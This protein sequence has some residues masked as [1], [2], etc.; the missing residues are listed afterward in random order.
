METTTPNYGTIPANL[1]YGAQDLL[2]G[3][4]GGAPF[5]FEPG[6][7]V[8]GPGGYTEP[9]RGQVMIGGEWYKFTESFA[10]QLEAAGLAPTTNVEGKDYGGGYLQDIVG[11]NLDQYGLVYG[12]M[13]NIG[14]RIEDIG[15]IAHGDIWGAGVNLWQA[16][17]GAY[18]RRGRHPS[19]GAWY[20][21]PPYQPL[22]YST[23]SLARGA[24]SDIAYQTMQLSE[25]AAYSA[26]QAADP[27]RTDP[28]GAAATG[29]GA[30]LLAIGTAFGPS[31][32]PG[33]AIDQF[34][35]PTAIGGL[36]G[37]YT[38]G[39]ETTPDWVIN[40]SEFRSMNFVNALATAS[41]GGLAPSFIMGAAEWAYRGGMLGATGDRYQFANAQALYTAAANWTG[42]PDEALRYRA[43]AAAYGAMG[44][45]APEEV[46]WYGLQAS[47]YFW[48]G[49]AGAGAGGYLREFGWIGAGAVQG[50]AIGAATEPYMRQLYAMDPQLTEQYISANNYQSYLGFNYGY[51]PPGPSL[52]QN[53]G[54]WGLGYGGLQAGVS[55]MGWRGLGESLASITAILAGAS[56]LEQTGV[57]AWN[58]YQA[59]MPVI[60]PG[61]EAANFYENIGLGAGLLGGGL[62]FARATGVGIGGSAAQLAS[63]GV[64]VSAAAAGTGFG[65]IT[66]MGLQAL[67]PYVLPEISRVTGMTTQQAQ[68]AYALGVEVP[69]VTAAQLG[70]AAVGRAALGGLSELGDVG[71]YGTM[72]VGAAETG[73]FG[74]IGLGA[75]VGAIM[76]IADVLGYGAA[77]YQAQLP[78]IEAEYNPRN[79][80]MG[81]PYSPA[82][83]AANVF[84]G[85]FNEINPLAPLAASRVTDPVPSVG[86][87]AAQTLQSRLSADWATY[88]QQRNLSNLF[89]QTAELMSP[90][91]LRALLQ[92]G[93]TDP[94]T[95]SL[96][97]A[98]QENWAL[99]NPPGNAIMEPT[100][101][102]YQPYIA[103]PIP[104][105]PGAIPGY[106]QGVTPGITSFVLGAM[107]AGSVPP[108]AATAIADINA[109]TQTV[110]TPPIG[111]PVT[112]ESIGPGGVGV[113]TRIGTYQTPFQTTGFQMESRYMESFADWAGGFTYGRSPGGD[114]IVGVDSAGRPVYA[115]QALAMSAGTP[116]GYLGVSGTVTWYHG[117]PPE[118]PVNLPGGFGFTYSGLPEWEGLVLGP[119]GAPLYPGAAANYAQAIPYGE[120]VMPGIGTSRGRSI[121]GMILPFAPGGPRTAISPGIYGPGS[122]EVS[123]TDPIASALFG[124]PTGLSR[125][126]VGPTGEEIVGY[127]PMVSSVDLTTFMGV[128]GYTQY[129]AL[130]QDQITQLRSMGIDVTTQ[131][132]QQ[133]VPGN[134]TPYTGESFAGTT[135]SPVVNLNAAGYLYSEAD[136]RRMG[137][138]GTPQLYSRTGT[139]VVETMGS[140]VGGVRVYWEG[141]VWLSEPEMQHQYGANW[142][143]HIVGGH[144][145]SSASN[146]S[147]YSATGKPPIQIRPHYEA[148]PKSARESAPLMEQI[149]ANL[150]MEEPA[151]A[152]PLSPADVEIIGNRLLARAKRHGVVMGGAN[153]L[154]HMQLKNLWKWLRVPAGQDTYDQGS[155]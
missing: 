38:P 144:S 115:S 110:S 147:P 24:A 108:L 39:Y 6:W 48:P 34:G 150:I 60:P 11:V 90:T 116:A 120:T 78:Q 47:S 119:S 83:Q 124:P 87:N 19:G 9:S 1:G 29:I 112:Q 100:P 109:W 58:R 125:M 46:G 122:F 13:F 27:F 85:W 3:S 25:N 35:L 65:M 145:S 129:G 80:R 77:V 121:V 154:S 45:I 74:G 117:A 93:Y 42:R 139:G 153:E 36:F 133:P 102:G 64:N 148:G 63:A 94:A 23:W 107:A 4:T 79:L 149:T 41:A 50:L 131:P 18:A 95:L 69:G 26:Y 152:R 53:V 126:N 59:G 12:A 30:A 51:A 113:S 137:F 73:T 89:I 141:Q 33:A 135:G 16:G 118:L 70:G 54:M 98:A 130:T 67:E 101:Q 140:P 97:Q 61:P 105:Q 86:S 92:M 57:S 99:A 8:T 72:E 155:R 44:S 143:S 82:M 114:S 106:P 146:S 22:P 5:R 66:Y 123:A 49:L 151:V 68:A 84:W 91:G 31:N 40:A 81:S 20:T 37:A 15:Y 17:T 14:G 32:A 88:Q 55:G 103:N 127:S 96:A 28:S 43:E 10:N 128:V 136:L 71:A 138:V 2:Y 62:A 111:Y 52:V 134:F 76:A 75:S 104:G 21:W 7:T 142:Q 56:L 132:Y